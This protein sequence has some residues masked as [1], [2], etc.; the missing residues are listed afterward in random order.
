MIPS[1]GQYEE[2]QIK[3]RIANF[4]NDLKELLEEEN[5]S[6]VFS[7][8]SLEKGAEA[9]MEVIAFIEEL[10]SDAKSEEERKSLTAAQGNLYRLLKPS[11]S[12]LSDD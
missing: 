7:N 9:A 10:L 6:V 12:N 11:S 1:M 5:S 2:L 8:S 4:R 3:A